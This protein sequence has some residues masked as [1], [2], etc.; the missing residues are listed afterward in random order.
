MPQMQTLLNWFFRVILAIK[1]LAKG[2]V[3][4]TVTVICR[5]HTTPH[6][7]KQFG[8]PPFTCKFAGKIP[9]KTFKKTVKEKLK[10]YLHQRAPIILYTPLYSLRS[11]R[12]CVGARLKFWRRSRVQRLRRQISLNYYTIPPA[13]QANPI[14]FSYLCDYGCHRNCNHYAIALFC[15]SVSK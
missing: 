15:K 5:E 4:T 6:L 1:E 2:Y 13:T 12:Y 11:W 3:S 9:F 14:F 8:V 7:L 10:F